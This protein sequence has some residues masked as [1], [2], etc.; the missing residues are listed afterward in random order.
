MQSTLGA[1]VIA[2]RTLV[3]LYDLLASCHARVVCSE[4]SAPCNTCAKVGGAAAAASLAAS[5]APAPSALMAAGSVL[6]AE[7]AESALA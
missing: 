2:R 3:G 1:E 7:P 5:C 6:M 4:H